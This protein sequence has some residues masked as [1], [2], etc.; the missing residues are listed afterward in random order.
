MPSIATNG[1]EIAYESY[2]DTSDPVALL[3][4]GLGSQLTMWPDAFIDRLVSSGRRVVAIDNRDI[5]LSTK[6]KDEKYPNLFAQAGLRRLGIKLKTPYSLTDMAGDAAGVLD[7]L[8][9]AHA[10]VIGVSMGGMIAQHVAALYPNRVRSLVGIMT[11]TGNPKIPRPSRAVVKTLARDRSVELTPEGLI[12]GTMDFFAMV[13]T[14]GEDHRTNGMADRLRRSYARNFDPGGV[15]RQL[16]GIIASGDFRSVS[17]K[18]KAP[19]L[20]IH[21]SSD[22]L[23]DVEAGKDVARNVPGARLE[24]IEGMGHD[25]PPRFLPQVTDLILDHIGATASLET[26]T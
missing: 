24:I 17:R 23:V 15:T 22:A 5:G 4:M 20:V 1:I 16:S 12:D 2:G 6:F 18:I 14:P 13:G 19:T 11:T 21:G 8:G 7:G 10:D 26:A 3:I 9:V 25:M